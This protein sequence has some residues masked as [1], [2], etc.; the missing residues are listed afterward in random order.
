[1]PEAAA[2]KITLR[3][4]IGPAAR[5]AKLAWKFSGGKISIY[6]SLGAFIHHVE[7]QDDERKHLE[8]GGKL[9]IVHACG[10]EVHAKLPHFT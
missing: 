1:M 8:T 6:D 3:N 7:L 4:S 9:I 10:T 5:V 2:K